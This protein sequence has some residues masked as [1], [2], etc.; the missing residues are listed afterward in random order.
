[1]F[2][3]KMKKKTNFRFAKI[4]TWP[5]FEKPLSQRN[6]FNKIWLKVKEHEYIYIF[7]IIFEKNYFV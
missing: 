4:V 1:M 5:K 3:F 2:R 7:E 6:F